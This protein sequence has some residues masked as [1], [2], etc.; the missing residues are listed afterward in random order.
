MLNIAL[1]NSYSIHNSNKFFRY[2]NSIKGTGWS[3]WGLFESS[4]WENRRQ[5]L[6]RQRDSQRYI[7]T[8]AVD[9]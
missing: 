4:E 6:C 5:V 3:G 1:I 8:M 7:W 2:K 9:L